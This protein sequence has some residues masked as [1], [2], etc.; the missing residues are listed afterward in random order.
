MASSTSLTYPPGLINTSKLVSRMPTALMPWSP[1]KYISQ[2]QQAERILGDLNPNLVVV[3]PLLSAALS[4]C[5]YRSRNLNQ[6]TKEGGNSKKLN[7]TVLAL[8]TIKDLALPQ[9]PGMAMFWKYPL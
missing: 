7:W 4:L 5:S 9:E 8:N 2:Y 6:N 1:D 3:Y